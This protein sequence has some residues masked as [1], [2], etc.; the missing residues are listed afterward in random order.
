MDTEETLKAAGYL[1]A[2]KANQQMDK[3]R[4]KGYRPKIVGALDLCK[5]LAIFKLS[6]TIYEITRQGSY[7]RRRD[8]EARWQND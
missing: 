2:Y 1:P 4:L 3:Y 8:L 7:L 6:K 5:T